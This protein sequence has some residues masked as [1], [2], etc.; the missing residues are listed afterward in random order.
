VST[1]IEWPTGVAAKGNEGVAD[2]AEQTPGSIGYVEYAYALQKGL[3]FTAMINRDGRIVEPAAN[4]LAAAAANADWE[5]TPG[6]GAML[7]NQPG[8][9]SW[10][11]TTATFILV[12][13]RPND[14]AAARE[15]L[16]FF[17]WAYTNGDVMALDLSYVPMPKAV[18]D[19]IEKRWASEI[20]GPDGSPIFAGG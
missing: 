18:V 4:T 14:V 16:K 15:A 6:N 11:M 20:A 12:N 7:A 17:D 9:E 19:G 1:S 8:A 10:P 13:K 2:D 3:T 5:G